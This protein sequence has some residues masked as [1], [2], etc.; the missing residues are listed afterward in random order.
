MKLFLTHHKADNLHRLDCMA[1]RGF[2]ET[3]LKPWRA[4]SDLLKPIL[5][6]PMLLEWLW[7]GRPF[8]D[9]GLGPSAEPRLTGEDIECGEF[10]CS[11]LTA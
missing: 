6:E 11:C 4:L 8:M 3:W 7:E 1:R 5:V 2:E 10:A 9:R